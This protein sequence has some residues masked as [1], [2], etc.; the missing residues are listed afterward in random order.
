M[1][2]LVL[3]GSPKD[4]S[5]TFRMTDECFFGNWVL[6]VNLLGKEGFI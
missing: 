2:I 4:K 1:K 5:D 3:N 6:F